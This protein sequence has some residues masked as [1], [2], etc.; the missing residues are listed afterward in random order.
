M[1]RNF[2]P[3]LVLASLAAACA[4]D[5]SVHI[6]GGDRP[7]DP[8]YLVLATG[9]DV[10][11]FQVVMRN[12]RLQSQPTDGGVDT[13][14][15][16]YV[17]PGPFLVDLDGGQLDKGVFTP[18]VSDYAIGAKGFYEMDIDLLPVSQGDV[19]LKPDLAP[20]L[21]KTFV[22][23]GRNAQGVPFTFTSTIA[24]VVVR[25]SVF[26]MGMNHN[27]VDINIEPNAWFVHPDG[28]AVLD[29]TSTDPAVRALIEQNVVNSID[30]Y[31]DDDMDGV[32]DP[33][34]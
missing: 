13:P 17:G 24:K 6:R 10:D 30:G 9:V 1:T 16:V 31:Q 26:R 29:P 18:L 32:P 11:R 25:E 7:P 3:P 14:G 2:L 19:A 27:N 23:E 8:G 5:L 21:G 22:I 4:Q 33:L 34:G 20:M 12:I 15:G 28:G